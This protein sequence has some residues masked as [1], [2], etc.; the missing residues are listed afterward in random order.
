[1]VFDTGLNTSRAYCISFFAGFATLV[2]EVLAG[3]IFAPFLGVSIY[4]W[5]SIIG[6]ILAG[7]STGAYIGGIIIDRFPRRQTLGWLLLL[8][9]IVTLFVIPLADLFE[10]YRFPIPVY[11]HILI[12]CLTVLLVPSLLLGAIV[13]VVV[14]LT[15]HG[16][17]DMGSVVGKIYAFS[18]LGSI[19]GTFL[20]GFYLISS[21]GTR[22]TI[23]IVSALIF[24]LTLLYG[25]LFSTK[26]SRLCFALCTAVLLFIVSHFFFKIHMKEGTYY[27]KE[28]DYYTI[29]LMKRM[30]RDRITRL[31]ALKL[32][33]LVHSYTSLEDP[34]YLEYEYARVYAEIL[35]W[36]FPRDATFTTLT[37]G[38]GGYTLPRAMEIYFSNAKIDVV[39]IDPEVTRVAHTYL[40]LSPRTRV[41]TFNMDGRWYV[42]HC[43]EKYD[44]IFI[45]AVND[46]SIPYHL[47]TKEFAEC[48]SGILN[49][50]GIVL[51][52]IPESFQ[53][54]LFLSSYIKTFQHVFGRG[55][56]YL[57]AVSPD[58]EVRPLTTFVV[59]AGKG[60]FIINDFYVFLER[61]RKGNSQ[62][63][64]V[65]DESL[66]K[67]L[68]RK[69]SKLITDDYAPV[70][71]LIAPIFKERFEYQ[72][73]QHK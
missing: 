24:M 62:S 12:V 25:S 53:K 23:L 67:L 33:S 32:D 61:Y 5:T 50:Q 6:V 21:I 64:R 18:A 70:D 47:T 36:R 43:K 66:G 20:T 34:L 69:G 55:N 29:R 46:L 19:T 2:V 17:E 1:M 16:I 60:N 51:T 73:R 48:L 49:P 14:R 44:I 13:P 28:S 7:I 31:E 8:S 39:E 37:I 65:S 42:M 9:G 72:I 52:N 45:D 15:L 35:M 58:Y 40:G 68:N 4:T 27:F 26:K 38:G 41:K 22:T 63:F 71:N 59:A 56:V 30:S 10:P 11:M 54:G 57:I 3:R